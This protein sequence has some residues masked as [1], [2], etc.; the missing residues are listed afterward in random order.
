M[1]FLGYDEPSGRIVHLHLHFRLILGER[2][3]KNYRLPWEAAL[4]A[5]AMPHPTM[6]IRILDPAS[7]A[8]LLAVRACLELSRLIQ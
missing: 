3:L 1:S 5:D 2:L 6:P 4:L 8:V 7:E